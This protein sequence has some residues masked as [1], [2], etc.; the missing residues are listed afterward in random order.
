[1][2]R[3]RYIQPFLKKLSPEALKTP[4]RIF[5]SVASAYIKSQVGLD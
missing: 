2:K 4:L 1:M 3:W 5:E